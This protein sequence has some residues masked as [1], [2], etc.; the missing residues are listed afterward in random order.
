MLEGFSSLD[1]AAALLRIHEGGS[2]P[3]SIDG[4]QATPGT[5]RLEIGA[6]RNQTVRHRDILGAFAG[7]T[8]IPGERFGLI[9]VGDDRSWIEV[10]EEDADRVISIM[11]RRRIKGRPITISR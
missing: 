3:S 9:E 11:S 1:I 8:G 4:R 6:G 10:P 5:V 7:E 2:V